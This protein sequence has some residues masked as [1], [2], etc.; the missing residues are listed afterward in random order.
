MKAALLLGDADCVWEDAYAAM[1]E[2][3]FDIIAA[4]NMMGADWPEDI[5]HW[6]TLHP[7]PIH[8]AEW[9][10]IEI[11]K[12][13]RLRAGRN[14][15]TVWSHWDAPGV[16]LVRSDWGGSSGLFGVKC[17]LQDLKCTAIVLAGIPMTHAGGHYYEEGQRRHWKDAHKYHKGWQKHHDE[18]APY[19]RS[20]SGLTREWL[21]A[22]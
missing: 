5:D 22:P 3:R 14:K 1:S 10:G 15:P 21:G 19:V 4:T 9:P 16:D 6:F 12:D 8:D 20:M 18:I 13:R 7:T 11:L 2:Y 17:L